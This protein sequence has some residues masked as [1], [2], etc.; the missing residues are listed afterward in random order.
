[1]IK[2]LFI[3][4]VVALLALGCTRDPAIVPAYLHID[5]FRI[6]AD[7]STYGTSSDRITTVWIEV[8][9]EE[10]G[11]FEL[12]AL[13]PIAKSGTHN[14]EITPGINLNGIRSLRNI[15]EFYV[16]YEETMNLVEGGDVWPNM[17][18]D[19]IAVSTYNSAD[20]I[21]YNPLED[22]EGASLAFERAQRADTGIMRTTDPAMVFNDP[23]LNENSTT[24]GMAFMPDRDFLFEAVSV[25]EYL[26][27]PKGGANVYVEMNYKTDAVVTV[28]VYRRAAGQVDQVPV[29]SL[30]PSPV[31]NKVYINLVTEVSSVPN[32]DGFRLF[33][34]GIN[35][36][37]SGD[38]ILLFDNIKLVY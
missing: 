33:I 29:V 2:H 4:G 28:G 12:P 11:V 3:F 14:V 37:G 19:S 10:L 27:F 36:E 26:D 24:S 23:D 38:K 20:H 25:D 30:F 17:S 34:G 9:G 7:Y 15:Y 35:T 22:F 5:D 31:W 18:G 6:N 13:V 21:T 32:A 1:M 8:D 16:P